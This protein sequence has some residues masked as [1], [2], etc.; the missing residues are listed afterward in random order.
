[1]QSP[2]SI[3]ITGA[4]SGIGA[5]LALGYAGPGV[6]LALSGRDDKRLADIA[7]A[8]R[9]AGATVHAQTIDVTD[10]DAC[11][12]W[13]AERDEAC[14]LE[15][16]IANA[17]ISGGGA[18]TAD[19]HLETRRIFATNIDGVVNT[20]LPALDRMGA[21]RRGQIAIIG[22]PA[23]F[24]GLPSA[25][26]YSASKAA[27]RAWGEAL[28]IRHAEDGIEICVVYPGFVDT[29]MTENNP[30]PMPFL[31]DAERAA[32]IIRRGLERNRGCIAFPFPIYAAAWIVSLM[33]LWLLTL[34]M[35]RLPRKE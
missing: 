25:P 33:P 26:A 30:F 35:R 23:G 11:T 20:V 19:A 15:L 6:T 7:E 4:S 14:P 24:R 8:C 29:R 21:R 31:M 1:M 16:V 12:R 18:G 17:G 28:R 5:A 2:T 10:R 13:I 27:V 9:R 22:S 3:L 32:R 34:T